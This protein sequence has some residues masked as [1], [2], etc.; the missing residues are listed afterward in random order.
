MILDIETTDLWG[1][2]CELAVIDAHS[3]E[4]LIDTLV[5]PGVPITPEAH[6]VHGIGDDDVVGAASKYG[7]LRFLE[8]AHVKDLLCLLRLA[9]N[10][11]DE[12]AWFRLLQFLD[13]VGPASARRITGGLV[14]ARLPLAALEEAAVA[15]EGGLSD[16]ARAGAHDLGLAIARAGTLGAPQAVGPGD[17]PSLNHMPDHPAMQ[18]LTGRSRASGTESCA[19]P[20]EPDRWT[21]GPMHDETSAPSGRS[22]AR[23]FSSARAD[24]TAIYSVT[25]S[26]G[27]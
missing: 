16:E 4:V 15:A 22:G 27:G 24:G 2:I 9:E 12:L 6:W 13:G 10:P 20:L 17:G 11:H 14:T 18:R 5:N 19:G 3:G 26:E 7:G 21:T 23:G 1:V 8:A 25:A